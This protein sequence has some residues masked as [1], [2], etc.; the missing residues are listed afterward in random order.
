MMLLAAAL[1]ASA[2]ADRPR[3]YLASIVEIPIAAGESVESFSFETWGVTVQAVCHV[4]LGWI[5]KA[6]GSANPSGVIEG[7]GSHGATW[8]A[9]ASPAPLRN[10]VLLT[11]YGPVQRRD[12][13]QSNGVV[14]A[15]FSG[16]ATINAEKGE[17]K[18]RL[19]Y[20]NVRLV[21]ASR[22]PAG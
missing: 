14:P 20:R 12:L 5:V 3:T 18:V 11:L 7:E 22:C 19:G 4:P 8:F 10:F 17:R 6:G 1:L 16:F 2:P 15:T 9:R 21:P 13:R